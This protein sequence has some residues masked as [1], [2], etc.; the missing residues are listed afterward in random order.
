[1]YQPKRIATHAGHV[2]VNHGQHRGGGQCRVH[3]R[4]ARAQHVGTR[5]RSQMVRRSH[6]AAL[7]GH[8]AAFFELNHVFFQGCGPS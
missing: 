4:T 3:R 6:H 2:R 1:M 5:L 8:R 7:R